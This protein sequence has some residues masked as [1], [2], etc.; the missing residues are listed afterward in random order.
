MH[1]LLSTVSLTK[2]SLLVGNI[3]QALVKLASPQ[4][5]LNYNNHSKGMKMAGEADVTNALS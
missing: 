1:F 2:D 3:T 5:K 4:L